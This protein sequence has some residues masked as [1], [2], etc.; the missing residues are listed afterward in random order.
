MKKVIGWMASSFFI[1]SLCWIAEKPANAQSTAVPITYIAFP[2]PQVG[3]F[4]VP[5][6]D[7]FN[8]SAYGGRLSRYDVHVAKMFEITHHECQSREQFRRITWRYYVA[9]QKRSIGAFEIPCTLAN[10]IAQEY[11]FLNTSEPTEIL[12]YRAE[13]VVDIPVLAITG[14]KIDRWLNFLNRFRPEG[15]D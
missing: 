7:P 4:V 14:E 12:Y 9:D 2:S 15:M 10:Q 1:C 13:I 5:D 3:E 8:T 6:S 11:G